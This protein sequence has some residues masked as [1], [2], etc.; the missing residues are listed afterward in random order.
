MKKLMM[1][2]GIISILALAGC[3]SQKGTELTPDASHDSSTG[4]IQGASAGTES[5]SGDMDV[6]SSLEEV[7]ESADDLDVGSLY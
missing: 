5:P 4:S 3:A 1:I 7:V 6:D 2:F